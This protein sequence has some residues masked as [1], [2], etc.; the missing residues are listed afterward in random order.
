MAPA[1]GCH[2]GMHAAPG[3]GCVLPLSLGL[4]LLFTQSLI[5]SLTHLAAR[6]GKT[7]KLDLNG[8]TP[9]HF[10]HATTCLYWVMPSCRWSWC[11][12]TLVCV[13]PVQS[14]S[15]QTCGSSSPRVSQHTLT[16]THSMAYTHTPHAHCPTQ[17]PSP[18]TS[19]AD[20]LQCQ[21]FCALCPFV[22]ASLPA[23]RSTSGW[24]RNVRWS[25]C[26]SSGVDCAGGRIRCKCMPCVCLCV[27]VYACV[28]AHPKFPVLTIIFPQLTP[29]IQV[30]CTLGGRAPCAH[31]G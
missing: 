3:S 29:C 31:S 13:Y 9:L 12:W 20:P 21:F 16:H 5:P 6:L 7:S 19:C 22:Q 25:G 24:G 27:Y 4:T 18:K 1:T 2:T 26:C 30:G 10:M 17:R 28:C 15:T 11:Q 8:D 14:S 23:M